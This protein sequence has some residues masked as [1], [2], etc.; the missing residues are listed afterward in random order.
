[1]NEASSFVLTVPTLKS[2]KVG[3][4]FTRGI[5]L[6]KSRKSKDWEPAYW[7]AY[8]KSRFNKWTI[9]IT[10]LDQMKKFENYQKFEVALMKDK[11]A[12]TPTLEEF[13]KAEKHG[14]FSCEPDALKLYV[15]KS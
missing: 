15:T 7:I 1:M 2:L 14:L 10:F 5:T 4:V 11:N 6:V 13:N 12:Y 3:A 8:K 9:H